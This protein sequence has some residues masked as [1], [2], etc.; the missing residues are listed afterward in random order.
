MI[1]LDYITCL[2]RSGALAPL[3][4]VAFFTATSAAAPKVLDRQHLDLTLTVGRSTVIG[5]P[6][7]VQ[8]ISTSSPEI[9][10][11][12]AASSREIL[13]N[14]KAVGQA[15]LYLWAKSGERWSYTVTVEQN[16][17]P[18]RKLLNDVFPNE[19]MDVRA[20]RDSLAL[21]GR[22][23]SQAVADHAVALL[24]PMMKSA[25][26]NVQISALPIDKQVMLRVRF[27]EVDRKVAT[28]FGVNLFSTGA[29]NTPGRI[30]TGQFASGGPSDLSGVIGGSVTGTTSK[31]TLSD[32]LDIFAFRPD[33]N[34]AAAIRDLQT[35]GLL[36]ILAEPNL[37][38]TNG[39]E[40]SFLVGGE[41]PVPVAQG[42]AVAGA[43]TIQYREFG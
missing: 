21:V 5:C 41:F 20:S 25:V 16:L 17:E 32:V 26:S 13:F 35:K 7:D 30:G 19:Q 2:A 3:I 14:A 33:L 42:G 4:V 9:V 34:L 43:I 31:F 27:A 10:D 6:S 28:S 36:Q 11:A 22:A 23:S 38:T 8:K 1:C 12:V 15:T 40:A 18:V 24:T 29:A 37:V 39:K